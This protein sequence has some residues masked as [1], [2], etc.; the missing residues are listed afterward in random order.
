MALPAAAQA[1]QGVPADVVSIITDAR[2]VHSSVPIPFLNGAR[3]KLFQFGNQY[4]LTPNPIAEWA[5]FNEAVGEACQGLEPTDTATVPLDVLMY[6]ASTVE[7]L[8]A[9]AGVSPNLIGIVPSYGYLIFYR[10]GNGQAVLQ[11][12]LKALSEEPD[13]VGAGAVDRRVL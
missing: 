11:S 10:I 5:S 6:E 4:I 9:S 3:I 1:Q 8:A 12:T 7:A 2:L 13:W